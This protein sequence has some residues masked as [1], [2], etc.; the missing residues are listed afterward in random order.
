MFNYDKSHRPMKNVM[1]KGVK[2]VQA[3]VTT[4][5]PDD[6]QVTLKNG[7]KLNYRML[8]VA[9]GLKLDWDEVEGLREMLG[10]NGVTSNYLPGLSKYTYELVKGFK[11]GKAIFTQPPMPIKC[12]GAPQKS[13]YL[14]CSYWPNCCAN[15]LYQLRDDFFFGSIG[16]SF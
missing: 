6:N 9:A 2:W 11:G 3:T 1:P 10:K 15:R 8:I 13:L 14:S 7:E 12:A 4:F 5:E 16:A